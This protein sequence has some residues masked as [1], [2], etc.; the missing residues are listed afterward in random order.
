VTTSSAS[1]AEALQR[2]TGADQDAKR[3]VFSLTAEKQQLSTAS[4]TNGHVLVTGRDQHT[5]V[6]LVV[7]RDDADSDCA[8]DTVSVNIELH[9]VEWQNHRSGRC[10][11]QGS[12]WRG[13]RVHAVQRPAGNVHRADRLP[14]DPA[15]RPDRKRRAR[16]YHSATHEYAERT[17]YV[18]P[19]AGARGFTGM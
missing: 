15:D 8:N 19:V 10:H 17:Q 9:R 18:R 1:S 7:V 6:F 12:Q 14:A 3:I 2:T 13:G 11:R 16:P 5:V 4:D